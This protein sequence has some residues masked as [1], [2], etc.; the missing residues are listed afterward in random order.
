MNV[1][2][3]AQLPASG[4]CQVEANELVHLVRSEPP[5]NLLGGSSNGRLRPGRGYFK[6]RTQTLSLVNIVQV[7]SHYLHRISLT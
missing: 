5:V 1:D 7:T 3:F 6:D 2:L 4:A